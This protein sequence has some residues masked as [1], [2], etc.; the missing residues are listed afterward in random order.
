MHEK[1]TFPPVL[2]KDKH[3]QLFPRDFKYIFLIAIV[4]DGKALC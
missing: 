3:I 4:F 1:E 2:N